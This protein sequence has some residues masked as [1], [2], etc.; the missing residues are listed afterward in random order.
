MKKLKLAILCGGQSAEHEISVISAK[1]VIAALDK[2]KYDVLVIFI[3]R[4]GA[5]HLIKQAQLFIDTTNP[6]TLLNTSQSQAVALVFGNAKKALVSLSNPAENYAIDVAF[7]VLHGAHGED[8]TMQ[9]LLELANIPYIGPGVLGSAI[10]MDKEVSKRLLQTAKIPVARFLTIERAEK[11]KIS[12]A[13]I[14]KKLGLPFF[15]KPANTG[16]SVG[17]SKVRNKKQFQI[18]LDLAWQYDH[19]ILLE[20]YIKGREIECSVLG[21]N[22][23]QASIPGEIVTKHDFYSYEAKYID[24][25]GAALIIPAKFPKA[26]AQKIQTLAKRAFKALSCEGMARVDFF[27]T[28]THRVVVNELNTIP[29]FTQ[30]SM[31]PKLWIASGLSYS[32]LLDQLVEFALER[33]AQ[34]KVLIQIRNTVENN[35]ATV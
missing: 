5:W 19:K 32:S 29:G 30:I 27:V 11:Q 10:C 20:Q 18:A 13:S 1:N 28:P 17:I 21:N 22:E 26:V 12:F 14:V 34:N 9:G 33:F 15:V 31:Y 7:P 4:N 16:S 24:P 8:G 2:N 25:N 35:G 23:P 3:N 6:E